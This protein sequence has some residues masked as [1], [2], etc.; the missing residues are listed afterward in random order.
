MTVPIIILTSEIDPHADLLVECLSRR[1]IRPFRFHPQ[2]IGTREYLTF[3]LNKETCFSTYA[4]DSRRVELAGASIWYRRPDFK[5]ISVCSEDQEF[6]ELES[7]H[8]IVGTAL[9]AD[10]Y[11]VNHPIL[12][13]KAENKLF[14]L[15]VARDLGLKM[16]D[17]LVTNDP[18]DFLSFYKEYPDGVVYKTLTQGVLGIQNSSGV[19]TSIVSPKHLENLNLVEACPCL[20]QQHIPKLCDLRVTIIGGTVFSVAIESQSGEASKIDWRRGNPGELKHKVCE[21]PT[22]V[23]EKCKEMLKMLGLHFGAFD[24]VLSTENEHFFLELNP[25]GQFA[26]IEKLTG[27]PLLDTLSDI[28]ISQPPS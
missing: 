8:A 28:L 3:R 23:V 2:T 27:L 18:K 20:L 19:F 5:P 24:F 7:K 16:P 12:S 14:Q 1:Q 21:M 26:W 11:W 15:K 13:Q 17:T 25:S 6:A 9:A 4:V 10:A 22:F